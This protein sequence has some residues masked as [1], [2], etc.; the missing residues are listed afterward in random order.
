MAMSAMQ[1][2]G[3]L[4]LAFLVVWMVWAIR[5]KPVQR[6]ESVSS[7]FSYMF[8]NVAAAYLMFSSDVSRGYLR[9]HLFTPNSFTD[10]LGIAIT[11]AGIA[12]AVWA[13]AYLGANWSSTVTVKVGHQ[14]VRKGPYRWVRHPI[15]T[16]MTLGM[17]GTAIVRAQVRGAIAVVLMYIGFKIK[18]KIEERMM[19]D[20]FGAEYDDYRSST[21]GILP[22]LHC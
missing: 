2:C 11:F 10:A 16:G 21:G 1:I 6:R 14:L 5:T 19:T 8:M 12:F 4:W 17:L 13:R 9:V 22:K 15:Y 18:S 20:S 3:G 7:R